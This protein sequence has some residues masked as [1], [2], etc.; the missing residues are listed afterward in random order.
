MISASKKNIIVTLI[1]LFTFFLIQTIFIQGYKNASSEEKNTLLLNI[2]ERIINRTAAVFTDIEDNEDY[3]SNISQ[4]FIGNVLSPSKNPGNKKTTVAEYTPVTSKPLNTALKNVSV[5]SNPIV[6]IYHTHATESYAATE[7]IPITYSSYSRSKNINTN[8]VAIGSIV[9]K[10]LEKD[11][12]IKTIH[13]TSLHDAASYTQSYSNSLKS[14]NNYL[15]KY[16]SI[17]YVFDIHRD[18][19]NDTESARNKYKYTLNNIPST[20]IMIVVGLNHKNSNK[21]SEFAKTFKNT[22]DK[23]YPGLM[24][25]ITYR[26]TSRFNQFTNPNA[27][28]FEVGSNLSTFEEAQISAEYLAHTMAQIIYNDLKNKN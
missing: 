12:G 8:M 25:P 23:L 7:N 27:L 21:N 1:F 6:L 10:I 22:S 17:Q 15:E 24:L 2:Y 20:K 5:P 13:D 4:I 18:G 16:P 28:L 11:Y 9:C 26:Q 19:L 3:F 14:I